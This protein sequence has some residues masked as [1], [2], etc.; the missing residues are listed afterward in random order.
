MLDILSQRRA[1]E[2]ASET[3]STDRISAQSLSNL[4]DEC[5]AVTSRD[6]M[7]SLAK[8][9]GIDVHLLESLG[10]HISPPSV[11]SV[12]TKKE[13]LEETQLVRLVWSQVFTGTL[14]M[15]S[16]CLCRLVGLIL[17]RWQ[18]G[19]GSALEGGHYARQAPVTPC[20]AL[21][22]PSRSMPDSSV[23]T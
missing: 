2:I 21:E 4:F 12:R 11:T 9:Y 16:C 22:I 5:K 15:L 17:P 6:E 7:A 14:L 1:S 23:K 18:R 13:E 19:R 20:V 8:E 3:P 10:R